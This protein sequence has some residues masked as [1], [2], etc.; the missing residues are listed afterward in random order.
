M[1]NN[2]LYQDTESNNR[3]RK[4]SSLGYNN[5]CKIF[6]GALCISLLFLG[7]ALLIRDSIKKSHWQ[8][9]AENNCLVNS[10]DVLEIDNGYQLFVTYLSMYQNKTYQCVDKNMKSDN[11]N[12]LIIHANQTYPLGTESNICDF[13]TQSHKLVC[14]RQESSTLFVVGIVLTIIITLFIVAIGITF[15]TDFKY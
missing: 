9:Q 4:K 3:Y 11:Q 5:P 1:E 13:N 15:L 2:L 12:V 7:P 6:I 14:D 8:N 10:T